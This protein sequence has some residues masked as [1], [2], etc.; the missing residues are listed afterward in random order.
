MNQ[1]IEKVYLVLQE[2]EADV[3]REVYLIKENVLAPYLQKASDIEKSKK[4]FFINMSYDDFEHIREGCAEF[5]ILN[6]LGSVNIYC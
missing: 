1:E 4:M 5:G 6:V 3:G 2:M